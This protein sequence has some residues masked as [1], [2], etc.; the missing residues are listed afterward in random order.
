MRYT[1]R[2]KLFLDTKKRLNVL[3]DITFYVE[4]FTYF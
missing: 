1:L 4:S 3:N 2:F